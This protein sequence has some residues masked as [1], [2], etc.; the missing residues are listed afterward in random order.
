MR[1]TGKQWSEEAVQVERHVTGVQAVERETDLPK[2]STSMK[3]ASSF[4]YSSRSFMAAQLETNHAT[5]F[6]LRGTEL[7]L[8]LPFPLPSPRVP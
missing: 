2:M 3:R 1:E 4:A 6:S 8:P 7:P 5:L